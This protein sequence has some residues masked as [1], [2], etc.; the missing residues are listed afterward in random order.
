[1][2]I[3]GSKRV[4]MQL[5]GTALCRVYFTHYL[6]LL[7]S[8]LDLLAT[9]LVSVQ[10]AFSSGL[11]CHQKKVTMSSPRPLFCAGGRLCDYRP[12]SGHWEGKVGHQ[13]VRSHRPGVTGRVY[14][15]FT[16]NFFFYQN[17]RFT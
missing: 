3:L 16:I 12:T 4:D 13:P 5:F 7:G 6:L 1:M 8:S 9:A 10:S 2:K 15:N 17:A 11:K 14:I